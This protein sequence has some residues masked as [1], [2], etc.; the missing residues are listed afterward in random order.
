VFGALKALL[1]LALAVGAVL[2]QPRPRGT[3]EEAQ[4]ILAVVAPAGRFQLRESPDNLYTLA[5]VDGS[6]RPLGV[7]NIASNDLVGGESPRVRS[8]RF[9][10]TI[11]SSTPDP[12]VV[13]VL[14]RAADAVVAW[15]GGALPERPVRMRTAPTDGFTLPLLVLA[16][17]ALGLGLWR[18]GR[19]Q[20]DFRS[21]HVIQFLTQGSI[22]VYW[23][24]YWPGVGGQMPLLALM[25]AMGFAAD[26][27][28]SFARFGSWRAGLSV[29]P[30]V[31]SINLFEWFDP[32]GAVIAIV[33]AFA[34]KHLLHRGGRH[35][36]NPS[37]AGLTVTGL[38]TILAPG[39]VHFGGLFHTLNVP[40]NMSEWILLVT[41]LPQLRFRILPVTIGAL[42]GLTL[43]GIPGVLRPTIL[44]AMTLLVTDPATSPRSDLGKLLFGMLF[45]GLL[46]VCSI[47]LRGI[48]QPDDFAK[49]LAIPVAN[50]L[51][52]QLDALAT[53]VTALAAGAR[54]RA[55]AAMTPG[56]A[57]DWLGRRLREPIPKAAMLACWLL[58]IVPRLAVEKPLY[59]EPDI[60]WNY[61]T[62]LVVRDADGV[63][64]C[65]RNPV[66]CKVFTFPQEAALWIRRAAR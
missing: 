62:P 4:R 14:V 46:P 50:L 31:F 17:A 57:V 59:F 48:G 54:D 45:G 20:R 40:P 23:A 33:A 2:A 53:A 27:L 10:V 35:I 34:S 43:W 11:G 19:I 22:F 38:V 8:R 3:P 49:I 52:P 18:R 1:V 26:A 25:L 44:I 24:L 65:G 12:S 30:V 13:P 39:Y 15:D 63:P 56:A 37:V 32:H 58:L 66:F 60:H 7:V 64:R 16:L 41:L 36:F 28:F 55:L 47:A 5:L 21:L 42:I 9:A 61:A 6:N 51:V 29:V